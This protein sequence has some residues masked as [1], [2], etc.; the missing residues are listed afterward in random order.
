MRGD[1]WKSYEGWR[2]LWLSGG[3]SNDIAALRLHGLC[4]ALAVAGAAYKRARERR[5]PAS[6]AHA[7]GLI[8]DA[9]MAEAAS[10]VR[11]LLCVAPTV[12][13]GAWKYGENRHA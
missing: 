6:A 5:P 3:N 2:R 8:A 12:A 10:Q 7:Q 11:R 1:A 4:G 9:A 13:N